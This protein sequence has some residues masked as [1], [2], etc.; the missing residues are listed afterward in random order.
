MIACPA[1]KRRVVG[2]AE[3]LWANLDGSMQCPA[4]GAF[5]RLDQMSRLF[6]ACPLALLL[7]FTVLSW[8]ILFS[9][10]LFVFST[11]FILGGW[12]LLSAALMPILALEPYGDGTVIGRKQTF[13]GLAIMIGTAIII[14]GFMS[15]RTEADTRHATAAAERPEASSR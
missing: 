4:C 6:I 12:R 9:S 2:Q 5:A 13:V 7:W 14:D 11:I 1:C 8:S 3:L 10:Y 15:Y